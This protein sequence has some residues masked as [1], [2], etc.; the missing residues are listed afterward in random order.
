[1]KLQMMVLLGRAVSNTGSAHANS[2]SSL[3]CIRLWYHL[4]C[5]KY[6]RSQKLIRLGCINCEYQ[7]NAL[8]TCQS[9][10]SACLKL[11]NGGI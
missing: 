7:V 5:V 8:L 10:P 1:M 2:Y 9:V 4:L 11:N 6:T 3:S